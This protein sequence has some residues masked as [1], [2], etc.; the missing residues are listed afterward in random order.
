MLKVPFMINQITTKQM[1]ITFF[2]KTDD[3][4]PKDYNVIY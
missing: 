4:T 1:I 3:Q 2:Y